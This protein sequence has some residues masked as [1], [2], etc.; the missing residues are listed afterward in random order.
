MRKTWN[1]EK[2]LRLRLRQQK[3]AVCVRPRRPNKAV[4]RSSFP[5]KHSRGSSLRLFNAFALRVLV[6]VDEKVRSRPERGRRQE[7]LAGLR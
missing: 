3:A 7:A 4:E 1:K 5:V 2:K 6:C